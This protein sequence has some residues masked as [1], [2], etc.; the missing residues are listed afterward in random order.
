MQTEARTLFWQQTQTVA[1]MMC[2]QHKSPR[3]EED[4]SLINASRSQEMGSIDGWMEGVFCI[5]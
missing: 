1:V 4:S 2:P 3:T 5:K